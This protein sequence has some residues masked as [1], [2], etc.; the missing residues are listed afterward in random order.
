MR[1]HITKQLEVRV[2]PF[3]L[4]TAQISSFS[5]CFLV[6]NQLSTLKTDYYSCNNKKNEGRH[7]SWLPRWVGVGRGSDGKSFQCSKVP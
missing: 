2:S 4:F 3:V 6:Q 5:A 7:C 1:Q